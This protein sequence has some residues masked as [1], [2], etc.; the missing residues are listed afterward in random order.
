MTALRKV[1]IFVA[2]ALLAAHFARSGSAVLM[3]ISLLVPLL[4]LIKRRW[5]LVVVQVSALVASAV[6]LD[7]TVLLVRDRLMSGRPWG[8]AVLILGSVALFTICAGL[9]L[10]SRTVRAQ[11]Q[12]SQPPLNTSRD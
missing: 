9:L 6:W 3:A 2:S 12:R 5:S 10:S 8:V 11:Y 4:L 1:P 7:T